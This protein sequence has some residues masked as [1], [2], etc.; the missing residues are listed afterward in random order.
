MKEGAACSELTKAIP[1]A[2]HYCCRVLFLQHKHG[3]LD[4]ATAKNLKNVN[5][6][7]QEHSKSLVGLTQQN[8]NTELRSFVELHRYYT[9]FHERTHYDSFLF[10]HCLRCCIVL[11]ARSIFLLV[12]E[13]FFE[14]SANFVFV[15]VWVILF[16]EENDCFCPL[17]PFSSV[18]EGCSVCSYMAFPYLEWPC[19]F[20]WKDAILNGGVKIVVLLTTCPGLIRK[21]YIWWPGWRLH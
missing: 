18:R 15:M 17:F 19:A 7:E 14:V 21:R 3:D 10:V 5:K 6:V 1:A 4:K 20:G 16:I 13:N 12:S 9:L 11:G 8:A 2:K